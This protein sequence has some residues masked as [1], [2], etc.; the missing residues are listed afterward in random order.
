M[1][2]SSPT[3]ISISNMFLGVLGLIQSI[4][5]DI[6]HLLQVYPVMVEVELILT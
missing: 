3:S 5:L 1:N 2:L 4:E 6:V